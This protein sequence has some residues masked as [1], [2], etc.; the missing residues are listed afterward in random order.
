[1]LGEGEGLLQEDW[2]QKLAVCLSC[3]LLG[4]EDGSL[5]WWWGKQ[6][7]TVPNTEVV[8]VIR[9]VLQQYLYVIGGGLRK[10]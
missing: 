7:Q 5:W 9:G 6:R 1:M 3:L 2:A 8:L 10:L 4:R